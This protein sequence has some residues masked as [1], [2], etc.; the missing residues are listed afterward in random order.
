MDAGDDDDFSV[1][2]DADAAFVLVKSCVDTRKSDFDILEHR[3]FAKLL[4]DERC[5]FDFL[6]DLCAG[7]NWRDRKNPGG[8]TGDPWFYR[9]NKDASHSVFEES[10]YGTPAIP[11]VLQAPGMEKCAFLH[12]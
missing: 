10:S 4:L 5:D 12:V 9:R 1:G 3:S 7:Q 2:N 11:G 8:S 6:I